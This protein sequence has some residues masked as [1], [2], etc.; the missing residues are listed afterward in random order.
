MQIPDNVYELAMLNLICKKLDIPL[1][2]VE[3]LAS[4][5]VK[6]HLRWRD[7]KK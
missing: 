2:Q 7:L 4:D 5:I 1:E 3:E 6:T